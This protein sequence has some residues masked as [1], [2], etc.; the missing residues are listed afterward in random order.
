MIKDPKIEKL[1]TSLHFV[2]W[3]RFVEFDDT[4]IIY[5]WIDKSDSRKDFVTL[6]VAPTVDFV[7]S[8][9]KYSPII[10]KILG[11]TD[12]EHETSKCQR[13]EDVFDIPN[14]IRL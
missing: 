2:K 3:D 8:S 4:I 7:T 6:Q 9:A 1:L 11:F 13:V 5:G 12:E 10:N 14:M